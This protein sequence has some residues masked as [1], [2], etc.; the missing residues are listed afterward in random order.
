MK[1]FYIF[2]IL[3]RKGVENVYKSISSGTLKGGVGKTSIIFQL[4]SIVSLLKKDDAG[5]YYKVLIADADTQGN[6]TNIIGYDR[7]LH[8]H[9]PTLASIFYDSPPVPQEIIITAPNKDLPN[10]DLIPASILM[11]KAEADIGSRPARELILKNYFE[12]HHD[13]F[14]KYDYIFFDT[15]PSMSLINQNVYAF[16][17]SILLIGDYTEN[18]LEGAQLFIALWDNVR[19]ALKIED[20]IKGFLLNKI[21]V[22]QQITVRRGKKLLFQNEIY[23][24]LKDL[25]IKK[26]ENTP[27]VIPSNAAIQNGEQNEHLPI[28]IYEP[29]SKGAEAIVNLTK[30]LFH[31]GLL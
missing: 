1:F 29:N 4:A 31:I 22:R 14:S 23:A 21:D 12:E 25:L 8:P 19:K 7:T 3:Y 28:A 6:I 20:N 10:I 2:V 5:N 11:H 27:I 13:F 30:E 9:A 18:S 26:G 24:D 15:N 16:T 17:D